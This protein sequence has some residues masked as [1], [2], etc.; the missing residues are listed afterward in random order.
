MIPDSIVREVAERVSILDVVGEYVQ[1]RRSGANH[2]GLC[3][4]HA[5]KT[6]SF[7]VNPAKE[8]YHCFGCG[9]G[10]NVFSFVMR[11]EGVSFPEAVKQLADRVGI[12][13]EDRPLNQTEQRVQD[14]RR[15]LQRITELASDYF[16]QCL[17]QQAAGSL[18]KSYLTQRQVDANISAEYG[19]G[20]APEHRDGLVACLRKQAVDLELAAQTG[21]I[22]KGASGG[23][24]DLFRNRLLFPIRDP[25]GQVVAFAGRVLDASLPK[26]INSPESPL[27]HKSSL[28]FGMDMALPA[29]RTERSVLIVEGY[30]DQLAL[31]KAGI[32]NVVATC[33]TALTPTHVELIKR[34]ADKVYTL[35]DGDSAGVKATF[36]SMEL[37]LEQRVPAYVIALPP[38]HDP[39][40]FIVSHG[41]TVFRELMAK[42][43]P[44]F[45]FFIRTT[46]Q[47]I[48]PDT[49][50]AKVR[51]IDTLAPRFRK[52]GDPLE[53]ELY[54]KEICRLLAITPHAFRKRMGN[55]KAS[56]TEH[57]TVSSRTRFQ[58][59]NEQETLLTLMLHHAGARRAV[60]EA[61][62]A[63]LFEGD[64][65]FLAERILSLSVDSDDVRDSVR[66]LLRSLEQPELSGVV[67]G[68]LVADD[69]LIGVDW[70]IVFGQCSQKREKRRLRVMSEDIAARLAVVSSDS[71]EYQELVRL[72]DQMRTRKSKL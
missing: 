27:Y 51:I 13:V 38:E 52:I 40:S 58:K 21:L 4:F 24:Y 65:L 60:E 62:V 61:G 33:G 43:Q 57:D 23:W 39:D 7:T 37:F 59:D 16:R 46:L 55:A 14:D 11:I 50:D 6:P 5:E 10:G 64:Y 26:Y 12:T 18:V 66:E 17:E 2:L 19:L 29:I 53:R 36:R 56:L 49:V 67:S 41:V 22:R 28:L 25:K 68:L 8:I 47:T 20:F 44:L 63:I 31:F 72:A 70:R 9:A 45:D 35:F 1:L 15:Q 30:F 42:A 48:R 34:H 3:P 32:K 71:D 54:E 69:Y